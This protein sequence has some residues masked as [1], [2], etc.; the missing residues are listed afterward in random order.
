MM[1]QKLTLGLAGLFL[2]S[3]A[4]A[5]EGLYSVGAQ[6]EDLVP[7]EFILGT[8][9]I[10]DDNTTPG[11]PLD[12]EDSMA[13]MPYLGAKLTNITPQTIVDIY[14]EVGLMYYFDKPSTVDD[15]SVNSRLSVDVF[16]DVS[17]RITLTS[18]NF[19]SYELEPNY[20]YGYASSRQNQEHFYWV[21]LAQGE[22]VAGDLYKLV[23]TGRPASTP[24]LD[25]MWDV[26]GA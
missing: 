14:A 17:E 21:F 22:N 23:G 3:T 6:P 9:F 16:H 1:H 15:E 25:E 26:W 2:T 19:L 11:G 12:G 8:K 20:A 5:G 24:P 4:M 7:L 10:Y 13:A 18:R